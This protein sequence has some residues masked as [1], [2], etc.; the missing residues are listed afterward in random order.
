MPYYTIHYAHCT[1][2]AVITQLHAVLRPFM[3]RRLKNDVEKSLLPKI[4]TKLYIGMTEMQK[5][6][7]QKIL[8]KDIRYCT[9][10]LTRTHALSLSFV[11]AHT[12]PP[13]NT[14]AR[15][16]ARTQARALSLT[17]FVRPS[18]PPSLPPSQCA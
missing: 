8:T 7:Y 12:H 18:V 13:T 10:A 6:W 2:I 15:T 16:H 17:P 1:N 5:L 14:H 11:R 9:P 4:E 3:L